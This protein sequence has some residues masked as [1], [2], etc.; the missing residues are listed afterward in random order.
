MKTPAEGSA[1]GRCRGAV[2][3]GGA[4]RRCRGAVQIGGAAGCAEGSAKGVQSGA[5]GVTLVVQS[6]A[7]GAEGAEGA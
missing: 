6:G 5:D 2:Q 4:D 3:I 1:E 7:E